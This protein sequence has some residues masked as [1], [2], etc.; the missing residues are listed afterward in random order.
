MPI[1]RPKRVY[2]N[3]MDPDREF[4]SKNITVYGETPDTAEAAIRQHFGGETGDDT[5]APTPTGQDANPQ[6]APSVAR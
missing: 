2:I 4:P 5:S 1:N 6:P 3:I